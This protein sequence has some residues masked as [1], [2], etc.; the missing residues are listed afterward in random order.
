MDLHFCPFSFFFFFLLLLFASLTFVTH[1][2][3]AHHTEPLKASK[4]PTVHFDVRRVHSPETLRP[5]SII[6]AAAGTFT[7]GMQGKH[8]PPYRIQNS[9]NSGTQTR[10][11]RVRRLTTSAQ[12]PVVGCHGV[13]DVPYWQYHTPL[14]PS[15]TEHYTSVVRNSDIYGAWI[16]FSAA[17]QKGR[18]IVALPPPPQKPLCQGLASLFFPLRVHQPSS[19][20]SPYYLS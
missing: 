16:K 14:V 2:L 3:D 11:G 17:S 7:T 6:A 20:S 8:G 10:D 12:K 19:A 18:Y 13:H 4:S 9:G 15:S 5:A 1:I